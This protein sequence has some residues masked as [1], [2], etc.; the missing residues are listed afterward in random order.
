MA[1]SSWVS[2]G[3][4]PG[5]G[6][7]GKE[8]AAG[9]RW[10]EVGMFQLIFTHLDIFNQGMRRLERAERVVDWEGGGVSWTVKAQRGW[11]SVPLG[12]G[13]QRR[14]KSQTGIDEK[15]KQPRCST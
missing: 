15:P 14:L 2:V 12:T 5:K 7:Q 6:P 4:L 10:R 3:T 11:G 1:K 13:G 8:I 9:E